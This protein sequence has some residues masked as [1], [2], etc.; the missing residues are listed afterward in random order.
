MERLPK[1]YEFLYNEGAPKMLVEALTVYGTKEVPGP[2]HNKL[3]MGW[4][5]ELKIEKVYVS[6][7]IAWCGLLMAILALKAGKQMPF[8]PTGALW[9]LNWKKFGQ[10]V[11][12]AMLGDVIVFKRPGGGHVG[13]YIGEDDTTYHILGGNSSNKLM[14]VRI[15]KSRMVAIRRPFYNVQPSNIR[16]IRLNENGPISVNES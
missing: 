10:E 2:I 11:K 5:Q 14:I 4:A 16:V 13:L 7:E 1:Q 6:D 12:V 3:I 15:L 9:A 8:T